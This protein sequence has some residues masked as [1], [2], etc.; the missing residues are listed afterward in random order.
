MGKRKYLIMNNKNNTVFVL[1]LLVSMS[2]LPAT[3]QTIRHDKQKEKQWRSMETGPWGFE[4]S[5]YY[6]FLHHDYSGAEKYWKWSGF[7]SRYKVRFKESKSN[8]KTIMPD[9][10]LAEETQRQKIKKVEE[11]RIKQKEVHDEEV[12]R[13]A[14]RNIDLVYGTFKDD[15]RR[16]QSSISEGLSYCLTKSKGKLSPQVDELRRQNDI[17]VEAIAYTHKQGIGYELENTK[18]EKAYIE[19]KEQMEQIV[20]RVAHLVGMAQV[21]Y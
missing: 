14:D 18:R 3:A 9:R 20:S 16:M 10:V 8:V 5:W 7:K 11:E 2:V 13:A 15:F 4:P 6:Y 19:Y 12:A 1:M 21:Y 17:I